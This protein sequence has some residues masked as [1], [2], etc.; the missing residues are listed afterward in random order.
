MELRIT[1][2]SKPGKISFNYEELKKA[3]SEKITVYKSLVYDDDQIKIAKSDRADLNRV[4]KAL[5]DE[6]IRQ[7]KAFMEPFQEF[8]S[9]VTEIVQIIDE[10]VRAVDS[11]VKDY[12]QRQKA[13]KEQQIREI[14]S[15]KGFTDAMINRLVRPEYLNSTFTLKKIEAEADEAKAR[16]EKDYEIL[17]GLE[18]YKFEA[19]ETYNNT[20]DLGRAIAEA[21][22]LKKKA[23]RK[24][25]WEKSQREIQEAQEVEEAEARQEAAKEAERPEIQSRSWVKFQVYI[26]SEEATELAHWLRTKNIAIKPI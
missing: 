23:E 13:E 3:I 2:F 7:E 21:Q 10:T 6:R 18:E 20:L 5:N 4:K 24:A 8:K 17:E 26:N 15:S 11:Q 22:E 19:M 9:Q 25:E 16:I 14:F 12:E 1:E